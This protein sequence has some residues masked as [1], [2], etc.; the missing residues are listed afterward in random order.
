MGK[1]FPLLCGKRISH[2]VDLEIVIFAE[3]MAGSVTEMEVLL[4]RLDEAADDPS[5]AASVAKTS[6]APT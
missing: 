3:A 5:S 6:C 1:R 2:L 4:H